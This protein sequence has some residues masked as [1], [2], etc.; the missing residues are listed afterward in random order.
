MLM[1]A[2][3]S[4]ARS[5]LLEKVGIA[6]RVMSSGVDEEKFDCS[7]AS[8]MVASLALAKANAVA[9][10]IFGNS[11]KNYLKGEISSILGCDSV[12]VFQNQNKLI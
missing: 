6:H 8:K 7:D 10:K 2:S 11:S 5:A 9:L 1:L 4:K 3:A 12:F